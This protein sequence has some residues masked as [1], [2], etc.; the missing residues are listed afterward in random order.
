MI[1]CA[2]AA[3]L[4]TYCLYNLHFM[5]IMHIVFILSVCIF[6]VQGSFQCLSLFIPIIASP[7]IQG[8]SCSLTIT[9][10]HHHCSGFCHKKLQESPLIL[11]TCTRALSLSHP[12]ETVSDAIN[13]N[14]LH[15]DSENQSA[16]CLKKSS[17]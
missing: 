3:Y 2:Y 1:Y 9:Y 6:C 12:I 10:I 16:L 5:N 14:V 11:F 4:L 7:P 8:P 13:E 15:R 17:L